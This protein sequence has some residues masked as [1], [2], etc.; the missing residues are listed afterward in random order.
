MDFELTHCPDCWLPAEVIDRATLPSTDGPVEHLKT[1]CIS[2]H[3]YMTPVGYDVAR[4]D[5]AA[6]SGVGRAAA[7]S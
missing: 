5:R 2:G 3:W 4:P 7:G 6:A 1:R